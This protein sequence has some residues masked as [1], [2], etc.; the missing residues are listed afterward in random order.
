MNLWFHEIRTTHE[1]VLIDSNAFPGGVASGQLY[2]LQSLES[3]SPKKL[4]FKLTPRNI[5]EHQ[6]TPELKPLDV[7]LK[8]QQSQSQSQIS[9]QSNPF[10]RLLDI[11]PRSVVLVR[12]VTNLDAVVIDSMEIFIK[13]INL[14]RDAMWQFSSS[15]VGS[16]CYTEQRLSFLNNRTGVV[17]YMYKNGKKVFSGYI[18]NET[19]IIYRSESAKLTVL[20]QLSREMW[21]FEENGEIMFHK[22]VNNLF[23]KIFRR[24]RDKGTHH[25][26]TIVLFTSVDLT[27]VPWTNLLPGERPSQRRDYF[28]VVVD[29]VNI[30]HWD[31]I[32]A[33]LR[34]EFANFKRDCMLNPGKDSKYV[35]EGQMLPSVKGNLLEAV[36]VALVLFNDRFRNTDLKHSLNHFILITPG[37]GLFDVDYNLLLETSKKMSTI[38]TTL[39]I[40][41]LSQPPLHV[42]PLFRFIKDGR[43]SYCVPIWCDISFFKENRMTPHNGFQDVRSMNY[44]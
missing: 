15:L 24:W 22:L 39:D 30:V 37:T 4:V 32:M 17:R 10:Q 9:L 23:P 20:I 29:Q 28:R 16:C 21:N 26:I 3:Q 40:V 18:N 27:N 5:R 2:E 43:V 38:D 42:T 8:Q 41:C 44:K 14:S 34:L 31:R 35:L 13:D 33:N 25:S 36:N 6:A 11:A 12:R 7:R 1:D 19:K